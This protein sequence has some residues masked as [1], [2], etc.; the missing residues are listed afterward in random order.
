MTSGPS[1]HS[2]RSGIAAAGNWIIDH[3]KEIDVYPSQDA[4]ANILAQSKGNGGAPYNLLKDLA[5]LNLGLSLEGVGLVGTDDDGQFIIRDC[6]AHGID[7]RFLVATKD[8]P[9][10]YTDVMAVRSSGRRTFFHQRGANSLLCPDHFDFSQLK[11]QHLHLGYLLLLDCL[12]Q[13]DGEY[14]TASARVLAEAKRAGMSTS[15]DVVSED[16]ERFRDM[17]LPCLKYADVVFMNEFELAR[18]SGIRLADASDIRLLK[19]GELLMEDM[20][21]ALVVHTPERVFAFI[22]EH[23]YEHGS[24][25]MPAEQVV[26]AVGAGDAFAAGYL[27]G[28]LR[29]L[30]V[31]ECLRFGVCVAASSLT[32]PDCSSGIQCLD[33][34]LELGKRH[35]YT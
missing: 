24:V 30:D 14:G 13:P 16:S 8:A 18:T 1:G 12:D 29:G 4:L 2:E 10:S 21:G 20:P 15:I 25:R 31:Q 19:A 26:G 11:A 23:R 28:F 35:G 34:C 7:T 9:T 17:V 6:Q 22:D 3:V 33:C 27:V 5:R 32:Q